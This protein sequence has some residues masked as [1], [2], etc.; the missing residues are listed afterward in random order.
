[1]EICIGIPYRD[2]Q[3]G[4]AIVQDLL[5]VRKSTGIRT[6]PI[7]GDTL[8]EGIHAL[9]IS[10]G[11]FSPVGSF[12]DRGEIMPD[13]VDKGDPLR[14]K[15]RIP[16]NP[17]RRDARVE[18]HERER[19][20]I[21]QAIRKGLPILGMCGGSWRLAQLFGAQLRLMNKTDQKMHAKGMDSLI[22]PG[23]YHDMDVVEGT[24]T[25]EMMEMGKD[26][27]TQV[28]S[29]HWLEMFFNQT[30]P[31]KISAFCG[32]IVEAYETIGKLG[33]PILGM[34]SHME[35]SSLVPRN[36]RSYIPVFPQ[37]LNFMK[38][39]GRF[40][41]YF[42]DRS[43][44]VPKQLLTIIPNT[45][46]IKNMFIQMIQLFVDLK[47]ISLSAVPEIILQEI[48][49]QNT[50]ML[51]GM[52][53]SSNQN[54]YEFTFEPGIGIEITFSVIEF[55]NRKDLV[56]PLALGS[57][58]HIVSGKDWGCYIRCVLAYFGKEGDYDAVISAVQTWNST[59]LTEQVNLSLGVSI[60]SPQ[61]TRLRNLIIEVIGQSYYIEAMDVLSGKQDTSAQKE[62]NKV[63]LI[64]TGAHFSLL[65]G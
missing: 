41:I 48:S 59:N 64:L 42:S 46:I 10:G 43:R 9:Y 37:H 20:L 26:T 31:V 2:D 44:P 57:K 38:N 63:N 56:S 11:P 13:S 27:K 7:D 23:K 45:S 18:R 52:S 49:Q 53:E 39:F 22:E 12:G 62:G 1:L 24:V 60:G 16:D 58:I 28:S 14:G 35:Y 29:V 6:V 21:M 40:A 32:K 50:F 65:K 15:Y 36:K 25:H 3:F 17:D 51:E 34:Q 5:Q 30:S 19:K 61:E 33:F 4:Q 55:L 54:K 47:L 8:P